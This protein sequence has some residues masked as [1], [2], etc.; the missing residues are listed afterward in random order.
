M[1]VNE[2]QDQRCQVW[3]QVLGLGP[4]VLGGVNEGAAASLPVWGSL[5]RRGE[6]QRDI[7]NVAGYSVPSG[8]GYQITDLSDMDI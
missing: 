3:V 5:S 4:V 6:D 7:E 2:R 1:L 8:S